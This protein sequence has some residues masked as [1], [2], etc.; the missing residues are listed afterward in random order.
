MSIWQVLEKSQLLSEA[1]RDKRGIENVN[2][3][4]RKQLRDKT[5]E[6]PLLASQGCCRVLV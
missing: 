5:A 3:S 1:A 4:L 2:E 6:A